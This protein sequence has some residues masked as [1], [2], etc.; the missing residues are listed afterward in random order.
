MTERTIF[1]RILDGEI[2]AEKVYEDDEVLVFKD[3]HPKAPTHLLFIPKK[4]FVPSIADLTE[5]TLHVPAMLIYKAK[6]LAD[7]HGIDGYQLRFHVGHSG[8]QEVF[9]LHLHFLSQQ[10]LEEEE[11]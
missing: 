6:Q 7:R 3:I 10:S 2:P 8:G 5:E 9:Y 11:S 4:E 1:H